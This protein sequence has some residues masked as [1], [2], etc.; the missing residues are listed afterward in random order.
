LSRIHIL[1]PGAK[2]HLLALIVC[3]CGGVHLGSLTYFVVWELYQLD[4]G[5]K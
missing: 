2:I 4:Y 3:L 1:V 5:W